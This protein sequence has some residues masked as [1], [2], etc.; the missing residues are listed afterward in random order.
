ML[1]G[2]E[3]RL[4]RATLAVEVIDG[5]RTAVMVPVGSIIRVA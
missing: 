1:S 2:K 4:L 5:K 3:F